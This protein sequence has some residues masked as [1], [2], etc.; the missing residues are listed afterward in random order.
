MKTQKHISSYKSNK[1]LL[2]FSSFIICLTLYFSLPTSHLSPLTY[3]E[4]TSLEISPSVLEIQAKP[5]ADVWAPF[6][7][8]NKS[9]QP[10]TLTI[11]YKAIDPQASQNGNVIFLKNGEPIQGEDKKIFQ[12][13]QVVDDNNNSQNTLSLGPKQSTHLRLHIILPSNEQSS[14]YYFSLVFLETISE[15]DQNNS[16]NINT[17]QFTTSSIQTGI[18]VNVLLAVGDPGNIQ[19]TINTFSTSFFRESGPVPFILT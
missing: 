1:L 7:I 18:G 2:I 8:T 10:V 4:G 16:N 6:T 15:I 11:G 3:A 17:G 9:N 13:I 5:P 19:G 12:K 14:D